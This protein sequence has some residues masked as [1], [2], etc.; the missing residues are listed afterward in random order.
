MKSANCGSEL[1]IK[2]KWIIEEL[3]DHGGVDAG[4]IQETLDMKPE[5][6][7]ERMKMPQKK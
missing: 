3:V 4:A 6:S 7:E 1:Q 2:H 5:V